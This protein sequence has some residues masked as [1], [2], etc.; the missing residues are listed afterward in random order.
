MRKLPPSCRGCSP[1]PSISCLSLLPARAPPGPLTR[2]GPRFGSP[3]P[4]CYILTQP[5]P[6]LLDHHP[7]SVHVSLFQSTAPTHP[8]HGPKQSSNH[9]SSTTQ[10][11][12]IP[13]HCN[14]SSTLTALHHAP[15]LILNAPTFFRAIC[16]LY[17][18]MH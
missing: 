12:P 14:C 1:E 10:Q 18:L 7:K 17:F 4:S 13:V 2:Y 8:I 3:C 15:Q 6:L 5:S 11:H 16:P 9:K